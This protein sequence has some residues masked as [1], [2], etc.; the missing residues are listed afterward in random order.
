LAEVAREVSR[1]VAQVVL[2]WCLYHDGV[3][4]IP[5]GNSVAH[6]LDNCGASGWRLSAA[7]F[8]RLDEE[9]LFRRRTG[10]DSLLRRLVPNGSGPF[11]KKFFRRLPPA[12]RRR[13]N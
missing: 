8:Q 10:V 13:L 1:T 9:I 6:V 11:L 2:N 3:V 12:L 4:A 7:Q 5:K